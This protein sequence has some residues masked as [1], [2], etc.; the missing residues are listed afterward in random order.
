MPYCEVTPGVRL[1]YEDFG[2]GEPVLFISGGQVTHK[3]WESQVA[4]LARE[5]RTITFDWRGTGRSDRPRDG[6]TGD[7]VVG[8]VLALLEHLEIPQAVL[9][10]HGLG[11]HIALLAAE[12]QPQAVK[13]LFIA[14]VAPWL[15]GER[16][17][18]AGGL[19]EEFLRF[20]VS[21]QNGDVPYAQICHQLGEDWLFHR[22]QSPGVY[23]WVL[24]QSLE[25]PQY[26]TNAYAASLRGLDHS[27]RL[28]RIECPTVIVQGRHDRKQ[29]YEGAV[30]FARAVPHARLMTFEESAH[31]TFVEEVRAFN[32]ALLSFVRERVGALQP[33]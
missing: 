25:W 17:G 21:Q 20:V 12:R 32:Q 1:Y 30:F 18:V 9:V 7:N 4:A 13:G 24:Q 26:V 3:V 31:M 2:A 5:C 29:R 14:A 8:D 10:G 33:A 16:D 11:A 27:A 6:Y 22:R 19:P 28:P 23:S 15:S